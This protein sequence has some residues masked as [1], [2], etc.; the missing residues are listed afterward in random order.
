MTFFS[1]SVM[2]VPEIMEK[3]AEKVRKMAGLNYLPV[4][5]A[6]FGIK[7]DVMLS[8]EQFNELI[9][10]LKSEG[11]RLSDKIP[12]AEGDVLEF[13]ENGDTHELVAIDYVKGEKYL[14]GDI[15]YYWRGQ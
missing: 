13:Y 14:I 11:F 2:K 5:E 6:N 1:G 3:I 10:M 12:S 8:E 7:T 15:L 4:S 9:D